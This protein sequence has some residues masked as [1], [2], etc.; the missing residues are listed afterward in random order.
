MWIPYS[1]SI[2]TLSILSILSIK[3]AFGSSNPTVE[4]LF[5]PIVQRFPELSTEFSNAATA[6]T[7]WQNKLTNC[8]DSCTSFQT[9]GQVERENAFKSM[10]YPTYLYIKGLLQRHRSVDPVRP[11]FIGLSAPQVQTTTC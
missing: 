11:M 3:R 9:L 2:C 1:T 7:E 6:T 5:K 10:Y 8:R 4:K